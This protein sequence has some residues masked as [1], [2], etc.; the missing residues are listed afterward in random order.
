MMPP[1]CTIAWAGWV[2]RQQVEHR[3]PAAIRAA[4]G[5]Q[6]Q[7]LRCAGHRRLAHRCSCPLRPTV[8]RTLRSTDPASRQTRATARSKVRAREARTPWR[9]PLHGRTG[10]AT[11]R[12]D[13]AAGRASSAVARLVRCN[14][15]GP[16]RERFHPAFTDRVLRRSRISSNPSRNACRSA[17]RIRTMCG[18]DAT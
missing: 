11:G 9:N 2:G 16:S 15:W 13:L 6:W 10:S 18:G 1:C 7:R 14:S 12:G 8:R 4:V 17:P 3:Q 5:A